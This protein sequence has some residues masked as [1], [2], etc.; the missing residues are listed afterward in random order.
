MASTSA[1]LL[2]VSKS[3]IW[4]RGAI[5]TTTL[6]SKSAAAA[7]QRS[8]SKKQ[9]LLQP[10]FGH[11]CC[12]FSTDDKSSEL[13]QKELQQ[14]QSE[15][16]ALTSSSNNSNT[17]LVKAYLDLSKARLS[18]LV[19]ATTAAGFLSAG[20]AA[21][22]PLLS[23]MTYACVG[24]ALCSSSAAALNQVFEVD[25]DSQMKRTQQRPLVTKVLSVPHATAAATVWGI[26]G[27]ALLAHGTDP[28]TTALGVSNVILYAGIY[29]YSKPRTVLNTWIGAVVGAVPPMIGW[30]AATG[31]N[32]LDVECLLLGTTLYLWQMPHF[33]A[34]SYMHRLDYARGGFHMV[35]VLEAPASDK[36]A[37]LIVRY[38][39]YLS[40]IPIISTVTGV[41]STMFGVEGVVLNA[42]AL[43]VA[44]DFHRDRTNAKARKVF[45]TSLWYLP[46]LLTLFILHS[47]TWDA[48]EVDDGTAKLNSDNAIRKVI[49]EYIH[50]IRNKGRELC[51]HEAVVVMD[52]KEKA[53]PVVVGKQGKDK[54]VQ[55]VAASTGSI[56]ASSQESSS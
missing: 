22:V 56:V 43:Y 1:R 25:R 42:Y 19:V 36:T 32:V 27:T 54:V 2:L 12:S 35:P 38:A 39:W 10:L 14:Q 23:T 53:C 18:A 15:G 17:T 45:L 52:S 30:S 5:R 6:A 7:W 37:S 31:G 55:E 26:A 41:T 34:L 4:Q 8:S 47:K 20:S 50:M 49:D 29:T 48:V 9:Q 46:C 33:F 51:V 24:T 16:E 3:S 21:T 40:T 11:Q 28:Y 13:Q 44:H